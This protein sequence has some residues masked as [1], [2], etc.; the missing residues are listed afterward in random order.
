MRPTLFT[1]KT[2]LLVLAWCVA[3]TIGTAHA[4]EGAERPNFLVIVAD[5]MGWS[6]LGVA[7]GEIRTPNLNALAAQASL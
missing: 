6:D 5:D 4:S 2:L 7:G 1:H 3:T